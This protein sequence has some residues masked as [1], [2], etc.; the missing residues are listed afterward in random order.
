MR[1]EAESHGRATCATAH[2]LEPMTG[3]QGFAQSEGA[4]RSPSVGRRLAIG[5]G[6]HSRF[7][8]SEP[9]LPPVAPSSLRIIEG[10]TRSMSLRTHPLFDHRIWS[11]SVLCIGLF[12]V[13]V[14]AATGRPFAHSALGETRS[15]Y[16]RLSRP[17]LAVILAPP[18]RFA[19]AAS[20]PADL[21]RLPSLEPIVRAA[22]PDFATAVPSEVP[23]TITVSDSTT[24]SSAPANEAPLADP[25]RMPA[26]V[27]ILREDTPRELRA[28]DFLPY[29][30][31]PGSSDPGVP[32]SSA[33]YRQ[34]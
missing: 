25:E 22:T 8:T 14:S 33:T 7:A 32:P 16:S 15:S 17:Y 31:F 10:N 5:R 34:R 30:V 19:P 20:A 18:L 4:R 9:I 21:P 2:R 3:N 23:P 6:P 29:F 24:S 26:P 27:R 28:V 12:P 13:T 11:A 1:P